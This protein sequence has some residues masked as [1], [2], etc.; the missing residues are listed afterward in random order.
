MFARIHFSAN[1]SDTV[2]KAFTWE[3][4][5]AC[6]QQA[7]L[8]GELIGKNMILTPNDKEF[9]KHELHLSCKDVSDFSVFRVKVPNSDS[10]KTE[11]RFIARTT[12]P[13]AGAL[14]E[15]YLRHIGRAGA[16]LRIEHEQ[17]GSLLEATAAATAADK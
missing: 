14:A 13:D 16:Q 2:R 10:E 15:S 4:L 6:M 9:K 17:Q 3:E 5:P 7:K 1:Y 11:L 12:E 8:T